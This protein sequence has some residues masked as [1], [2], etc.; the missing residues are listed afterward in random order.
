MGRR[1]GLGPRWFPEGC[2]GNA[3]V[4]HLENVQVLR[5]A[6]RV[7]DRDVAWSR[8]HQRACQWRHPANMVAFSIDLVEADSSL[9]DLAGNL[10]DVAT[11]A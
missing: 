7:K 1:G 11:V 3:F 9:I 4:T 10:R 5:T 2:D 6:R 8:L